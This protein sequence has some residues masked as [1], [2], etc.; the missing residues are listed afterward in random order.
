MSCEKK[1]PVIPK[2]DLLTLPSLTVKHFDTVVN[3]SGRIQ[4]EL[5]APL[6]E[7]YDKADPPYS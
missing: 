3:D 6:L 7:Q 4:L 5:S 1:I 2:S